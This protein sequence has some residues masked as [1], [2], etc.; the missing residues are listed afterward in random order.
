MYVIVELA[1]AWNCR[2]EIRNDI[3]RLLLLCSSSCSYYFCPHSRLWI[4][5]C[6]DDGVVDKLDLEGCLCNGTGLYPTILQCCRQIN[7]EATPILYEENRFIVSVLNFVTAKPYVR[8]MN[9][10]HFTRFS[11]LWIQLVPTP[12]LFDFIRYD[13]SLF[14]NV[15][16]LQ[17]DGS[18]DPAQLAGLLL[19][20]ADYLL[21]IPVLVFCNNTPDT[22]D[23]LQNFDKELGADLRTCETNLEKR[24]LGQPIC[25]KMYEQALGD[26]AQRL[27]TRILRCRMLADGSEDPDTPWTVTIKLESKKELHR[28]KR[29]DAKHWF[30]SDILALGS[31]SEDEDGGKH[32][33]PLLLD[34]QRLISHR[35]CE[36]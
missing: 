27:S 33:S 30:E 24:S 17:V 21:E 3:Y 4:H 29:Y 10:S 11:S 34:D 5:R 28:R 26:A 36:Y 12:R 13:F 16:R 19:A 6:R 9:Y 25:Q 2:L 22:W 23:H 8:K 32:H 15:R 7:D 20:A 18:W 35:P 31:E 14:K 1:A